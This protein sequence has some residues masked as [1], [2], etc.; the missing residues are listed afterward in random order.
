MDCKDCRGSC[1]G[2]STDAS[3]PLEDMCYVHAGLVSVLEAGHFIFF[4]L[5]CDQTPDTSHLSKKGLTLS[6]RLR[7]D[8]V[9]QGEKSLEVQT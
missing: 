5:S 7:R 2:V 4:S 1:H 8:T 9:P 6:G 3:L